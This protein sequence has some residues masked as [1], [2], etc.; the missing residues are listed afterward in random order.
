MSQEKIEIFEMSPEGSIKKSDKSL[1]EWTN[2]IKNSQDE[3]YKKYYENEPVYPKTFMDMKEGELVFNANPHWYDYTYHLSFDFNRKVFCFVTGGNQSCGYEYEGT[4]TYDDKS[5]TLNYLFEIDPYESGM[6]RYN[7]DFKGDFENGSSYTG[8][9]EGITKIN[10]TQTFNYLLIKEVKEHYCG[11]S[12][13]RTHLTMKIDQNL[14]PYEMEDEEQPIFEQNGL[15]CSNSGGVATEPRSFDKLSEDPFDEEGLHDSEKIFYSYSIF[16]SDTELDRY[17]GHIV[18]I[19]KSKEYINDDYEKIYRKVIQNIRSKIPQFPIQDL[20]VDFLK[21]IYQD[22]N[23]LLCFYDEAIR[24]M[25]SEIRYSCWTVPI[26]A[27]DGNIIL[28]NDYYIEKRGDKPEFFQL[29]WIRPDGKVMIINSTQPQ[30]ETKYFNWKE[31]TDYSKW[32]KF[33]MGIYHKERN[34]KTEQIIPFIEFL[35]EEF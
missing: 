23:F 5:F 2:D 4:F 6:G 16:L 9:T 29:L 28:V 31:E 32:D 1:T 17:K 15:L 20:D 11:H 12:K 7:K 14:C 8:L 27:K 33:F 35:I 18:K 13:Q 22:E 19:W 34:Y 3:S 24:K 26:Y 30:L 25:Y 21:K 10:I